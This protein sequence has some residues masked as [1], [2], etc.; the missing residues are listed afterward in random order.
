MDLGKF[1]L[2]ELRPHFLTV[3]D[4]RDPDNTSQPIKCQPGDYVLDYQCRPGTEL[5]AE[6]ARL[7][8]PSSHAAFSFHSAVFMALYF[9]HELPLAKGYIVRSRWRLWWLWR[10]VD[11]APL[12][13]PLLEV[14]S[15]V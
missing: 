10:A 9:H 13:R 11:G 8:F 5:Y 7:S 12:V 6:E 15:L 4:P 14:T 3:C 1:Y 2:G